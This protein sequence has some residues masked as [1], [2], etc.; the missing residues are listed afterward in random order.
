MMLSQTNRKDCMDLHYEYW[1]SL[2]GI[3]YALGDWHFNEIGHVTIANRMYDFI[4][5]NTNGN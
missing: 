5:G 3:I 2:L 4:I 1:Q